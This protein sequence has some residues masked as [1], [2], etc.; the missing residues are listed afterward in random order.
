MISI[1]IPTLNE[2]KYLS[3]LIKLIKKQNIEE[4]YE[5]IVSDAGSKDRTREIAR[6]HGCK[7][8]EGGLP[9]KGRNQAAK[10]AK[11]DK[12]LFLDAEAVI[13]KDF[14]KK[15]IEEFKKRNLVIASCGIEP[16]TKYKIPKFLHNLLYNWPAR[17]LENIF[18]YASSFILVKKEIHDKLGGFDEGIKIAEDH[19]YIRHAMKFGKVGFLRSVKQRFVPR[20]YLKEGELATSI[21]YL[22]CN[23]YNVFIGEVRKDFFNY[24]FGQYKRI[25]DIEKERKQGGIASGYKFLLN[26]QWFI[27]AF[28][29]L[30][31][32]IFSWIIIFIFFSPKLIFFQIKRIF[33]H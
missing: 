6:S 10:I 19:A 7:V 30:L 12:L 1:I 26:P 5:I 29:F 20:R 23:L 22:L 15:A 2:E 31:L 3:D 16:V 9:A 18:P 24:E 25:R 32:A 4:G 14:C 28:I 27:L 17:G 11:G 33:A 8:A 13:E 21:K